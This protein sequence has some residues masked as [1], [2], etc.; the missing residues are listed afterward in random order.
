MPRN[1]A[2]TNPRTTCL[3]RYFLFETP[4]LSTVAYID[5][6]KISLTHPLCDEAIDAARAGTGA[7]ISVWPTSNIRSPY[8]QILDIRQPKVGQLLALRKHIPDSAVLTYIELAYDF[9]TYGYDSAQ[10]LQ[11]EFDCSVVKTYQRSSKRYVSDG[12]IVGLHIPGREETAYTNR[13][14]SASN[15][16]SYSSRPSKI[17]GQP[18]LHVELRLRGKQSLVRAGIRTFS[19]L[20]TFDLIGTLRA[21]TKMLVPK[22]NAI[23]LI[24]RDLQANGL[25]RRRKMLSKYLSIYRLSNPIRRAG[26]VVLRSCMI[27]E[28]FGRYDVEAVK[29]Y[30]DIVNLDLLRHFERAP[31]ELLFPDTDVF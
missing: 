2:N 30:G 13:R 20:A 11:R 31:G 7:S 18:C 29:D 26:N 6:L 14:R 25:I 19:D 22:S 8:R 12:N 17:T 9:C 21:R 3:S 15:L 27:D 10:L 28:V 24:G 1:S 4:V 16:V 23:E 5:R